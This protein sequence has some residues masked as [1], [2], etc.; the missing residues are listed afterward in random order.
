MCCE[1]CESERLD[2][3]GHLCGSRRKAGAS[4]GLGP[5]RKQ[6]LGQECACK[7]FVWEVIP[8]TGGRGG[9]QGNT[10]RGRA[11]AMTVAD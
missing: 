8:G 9:I 6:A 4:P 10:G 5:P 1:V 2:L 11:Q 3:H 7:E